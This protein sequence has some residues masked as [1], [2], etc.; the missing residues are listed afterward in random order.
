MNETERKQLDEFAFAHNGILYFGKFCNGGGN[1]TTPIPGGV[2]IRYIMP[3]IRGLREPV[4]RTE[5]YAKGTSVT[6]YPPLPEITDN[7]LEFDGYT[8]TL[9]ELEN[10]QNDIDVG[11]MLKTVDGKSYIDFKTKSKQSTLL[12]VQT[13]DSGTTIHIDWGDGTYGDY[14]G[15]FSGYK[16]YDADGIYTIT[17]EKISGDGT[18]DFKINQNVPASAIYVGNNVD[19][20][21]DNMATGSNFL[22]ALIIPNGVKS[23][24]YNS[25]E[26]CY[27]LTSVVIPS[28][29]NSIGDTSFQ[30]C[31]AL[32]Y[33]CI[34]NRTMN[35]GNASFSICNIEHINI[36]DSI[37]SMVGL[38]YMNRNLTPTVFI[39]NNVTDIGNYTFENCTN[40]I[41]L[42]IPS[43]VTNIG[44]GAFSS[45]YRI[46]KYVFY[47]EIPPTIANYTF[48]RLSPF[49][50]IYVPDNSLAAYQTAT[51]WAPLANQIFPLSQ[52]PESL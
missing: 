52:M 33:I 6:A 4:Y 11:V 5:Y 27:S 26:T 20:I 50:K 41:Y 22:S 35:I 9:Q 8:H 38:L 29:V 46:T 49:A 43:N 42:I 18:Y 31:H 40:L 12:N 23:I 7:R 25:F 34:P 32:R 15:G 39:P 13:S 19:D 28:S 44:Q 2:R 47:S 1:N 48:D 24:G 3:S 16:Y 45:C 30:M 10:L 21:V 37:T 17:I 14:I 36:P 51:N